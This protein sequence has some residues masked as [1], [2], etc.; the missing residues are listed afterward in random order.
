MRLLKEMPSQQY[1]R[2]CKNTYKFSSRKYALFACPA[3]GK[4]IVKKREDGLKQLVCS[5]ECRRLPEGVHEHS[6]RGGVVKHT[7]GYIYVRI[8]RKYILQHRA[9][10]SE[11]LGRPLTPEEVVHHINGKKDDNR[12]VN[13][14]LFKN[15]GE[16]SLYHLQEATNA[17]TAWF[18]I[19]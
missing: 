17:Q 7:D 4:E 9:V 14:M 12:L 15:T 10:M 6:W 8:N 18:K 16:H 5:R 3:C 13:L 2:K 19:R 1:Y 11:Y